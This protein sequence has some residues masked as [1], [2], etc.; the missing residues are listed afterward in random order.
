MYWHEA[1]F[2]GINKTFFSGREVMARATSMNRCFLHLHVGTV[3][4][5]VKQSEL[6]IMAPKPRTR[7]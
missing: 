3:L 5:I 2:E 7:I 4:V 6:A 1:N